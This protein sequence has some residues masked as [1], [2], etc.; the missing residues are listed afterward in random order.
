M[1]NT[2]SAEKRQRIALKRKAINKVNV[3]K[4]KT[5]LKKAEDSIASGDLQKAAEDLK[6]AASTMDKAVGKGVVHPNNA[7][8]HKSR[9]QK[10]LNRAQ[11]AA[12]AK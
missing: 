9:L 3:S 8:R 2:K 6:A 5:A 12:S 10:R 1:A 11:A 7:A 4:T